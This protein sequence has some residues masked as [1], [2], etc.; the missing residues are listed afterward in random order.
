MMWFLIALGV[1]LV[2]GIC[3]FFFYRWIRKLYFELMDAL[4]KCPPFWGKM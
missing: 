2:L 4:G 1:L 3:F